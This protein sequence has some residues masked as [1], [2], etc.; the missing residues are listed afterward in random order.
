M[1]Q[2][3]RIAEERPEVKIILTER[4]IL[5]SRAIFAESLIESEAMDEVE[6][7]IYEI[8]F[9]DE[10]LDWMYPKGMI[11][12]KVKPEICL[13]RIMKRARW[14]EECITIDWLKHCERR[15]EK[16]IDE[17]DHIVS[18]IIDSNTTPPQCSRRVKRVIGWCDAFQG[19]KMI[20]NGEDANK[21]MLESQLESPQRED[22]ALAVKI[23][24]KGDTKL[25]TLRKQSYDVLL[26]SVK[27]SFRDL[28]N[29]GKIVRLTYIRN[30]EEGPVN[31]N[32][33]NE[34]MRAIAVMRRK[35]SRVVK[36]KVQQ[37]S[38]E[39]KVGM[40]TYGATSRKQL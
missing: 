20:G 11:Y 38:M 22:Q 4:S 35:N 32:D 29:R 27:E 24:H 13:K 31:I 17:A 15:H 9:N 8:L 3:R 30:I 1:K 5:S 21:L 34:L 39:L 23:Q 26:E 40:V 28:R 33:D 10:S 16:M 36:F 7:E 14:E 2:L 12:L 6:A 18:T 37:D 25:I 19:M